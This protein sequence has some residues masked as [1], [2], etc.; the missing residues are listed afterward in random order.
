MDERLSVPPI[1]SPFRPAIHPRFAEIDQQTGEW[2][3]KFG[4]GSAALRGRLVHQDIGQLAARILPDAQG[5]VVRILSDFVMWLFGVDDGCCEEG[6]EG[7]DP[8]DLMPVL[9]RLLRVAQSPAAALLPDDPLARS[10]RDLRARISLFATPSQAARWVEHIR[11]YFMALV[12]EAV[13]RSRGTI[14]RLDDYTV[15]RIGDGAAATVAPILEF[16]YGYEL[17][18]NERDA[19]AVRALSEMACFVVSWDNDIFSF[20]KESRADAHV[21]NAVKVLRHEY[22]MTAGDALALAIAQRDRV[23][24]R[25]LAVR[26]AV[27]DGASP[28]LH[29]YVGGLGTLVRAAQDWGISSRRYTC[30]DDPAD[31]PDVFTDVPTDQSTGPLPIP[32]ISWWWD[33]VPA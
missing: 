26:E 33:G 27:L 17:D 29:R 6:D 7:A 14:P 10:M 22:G 1:Y 19:P 23:L 20:H 11:E 31:L 4:I 9:A 25:F 15:I 24:S 3:E 2:A 12:W 13:H 30:P 28:E 32:S 5:D 8:H 18:P 21:L 16:A